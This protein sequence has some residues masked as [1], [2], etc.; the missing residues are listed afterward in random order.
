MSRLFDPTH[1]EQVAFDKTCSAWL[2][3]ST[4]PREKYAYR[5]GHVAGWQNAMSQDMPIAWGVRSRN[6]DESTDE[7]SD[8]SCSPD[9]AQECASELESKCGE[10]FDAVPLYAHP[11]GVVGSENDALR[12]E[13]YSLREE[14]VQDYLRLKYVS[15]MIDGIGDVDLHEEAAIN[16]SAFGREEPNDDDY[17]A[18]VRTAIDTAAKG[19]A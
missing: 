19:K 7:W 16:A 13:N 18:A 17:L 8:I 2:T 10:P 15:R 5:D 12:T 4:S 14:L 9:V 1:P 3:N 11:G 6:P